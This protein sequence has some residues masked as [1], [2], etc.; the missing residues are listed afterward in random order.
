MPCRAMRRLPADQLPPL[1]CDRAFAVGQHAHD[2]TH[3]R[4]PAP[5]RPSNV[6]TSPA[7][8]SNVMPCRMWLSP[9]QRA[10]PERRLSHD[11]YPYR[12][13][14]PAGSW[15][16]RRRV[17]LP[18]NLAARRTVIR[19]DEIRNH[20]QIVLY[21]QDRA[22]LGDAPDQRRRALDVPRL[23]CPPSAR[24]AAASRDPAPASLRSRAPVCA[25]RATRRLADRR[26]L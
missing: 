26:R 18:E 25:R 3:G 10:R 16:P 22:V 8:T 1:V 2:R 15:R 19:S 4:L 9:Y 14:P 21:H 12:P 5:L 7:F 13:R 11:P 24:R 17:P 20:R 23:P 6:T